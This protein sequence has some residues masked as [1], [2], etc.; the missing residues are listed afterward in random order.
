M[1]SS[2]S[3]ASVIPTLFHSFTTVKERLDDRLDGRVVNRNTRGEV[4][5]CWLRWKCIS[6]WACCIQSMERSEIRRRECI[7]Y[8]F[9]MQPPWHCSWFLFAEWHEGQICLF[10]WSWGCSWIHGA[11]FH[12]GLCW[13]NDNC[14]PGF[15][16]G[17]LLGTYR[18]KPVGIVSVKNFTE[19]I[20]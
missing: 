5:F 20:F 1:Y 19:L 15:L 9:M 10:G 8:R 11:A 3:C 6:R 2:S 14:S 13:F 16:L 18:R 7:H 12:T 4:A 17:L